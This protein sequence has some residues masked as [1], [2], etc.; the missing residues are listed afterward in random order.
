MRAVALPLM[1]C[2][3]IEATQRTCRRVGTVRAAPLSVTLPKYGTCQKRAREPRRAF[4]TDPSPM[5]FAMRKQTVI[6]HSAVAVHHHAF[7][8]GA[9]IHEEPVIVHAPLPTCL[10]AS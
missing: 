6:M 2:G 7:A 4:E 8:M 3:S 9:V 1:V 10:D 5:W